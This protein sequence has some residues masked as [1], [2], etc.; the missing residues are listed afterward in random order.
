[1]STFVPNKRVI[2]SAK[3]L[4]NCLWN[5]KRTS[6]TFV[7]CEAQGRG[8]EEADGGSPGLSSAAWSLGLS[9]PFTLVQG[10]LPSTFWRLGT[11]QEALCRAGVHQI[12]ADS[13]FQP[14]EKTLGPN[15]TP[16]KTRAHLRSTYLRISV[17]MEQSKSK[18]HPFQN[19]PEWMDTKLRLLESS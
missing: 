13:G 4:S 8:V 16:C 17:F 5:L 15:R 19:V 2:V 10:G 7:W 6:S 14:R 11:L 18:A 3:L 12:A 9:L 1:M